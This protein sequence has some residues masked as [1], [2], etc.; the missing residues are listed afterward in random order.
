MKIALATILAL[1]SPA[2][3]AGDYHYGHTVTRTCY[4]TRVREEYIPPW[5]S[6]YGEGYI[7]KYYEKVETPCFTHRPAPRSYPE[8]YE[9]SGPD[10]NSCEEG[11]FLGAIL[12][13][14]AAAAL[15]EKDAMGWSIPLGVVS[16][17]LIGCQVDGG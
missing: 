13:G 14:G 17:A 4:E 3:M 16:G 6:N 1:T 9:H 2:V 5:R 10:L 8:R 7:N 15:S 11:S 12:G